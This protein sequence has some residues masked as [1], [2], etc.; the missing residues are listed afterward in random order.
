LEVVVTRT[1]AAIFE[2]GVLKPLEDPGLAE[3]DLVE[4]EITWTPK[5]DAEPRTRRTPGSAK[6]LI[7]MA[8]DFDEPLEDFCDYV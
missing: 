3:H 8:A 4:V 6:G 7:K 5:G 2:G 1:L